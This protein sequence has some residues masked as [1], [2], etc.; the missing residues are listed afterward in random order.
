MKQ[1]F[2]TVWLHETGTLIEVSINFACSLDKTHWSSH[3]FHILLPYLSRMYHP[4]DDGCVN[5]ELE[6]KLNCCSSAL[7]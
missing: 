3:E 4:C 7:R 6:C 2:Q 5:G 1:L